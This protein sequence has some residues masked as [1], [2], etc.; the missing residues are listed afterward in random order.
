MKSIIN[1]KQL[2]LFVILLYFTSY[3]T[4]CKKDIS[5]KPN[6]IHN[7]SIQN[8]GAI[9]YSF[10]CEDTAH[11]WKKFTIDQFSNPIFH[12]GKLSVWRVFYDLNDLNIIYYLTEEIGIQKYTLWKYN[13]VS[14]VKTHLADNLLG[15][16][17]INKNGWLVYDS[18]TDLNLYRIKSNGDSLKQLTFDG[19]S[20]FPRWTSDGKHIWFVN[21][22]PTLGGIFKMDFNGNRLDTLFNASSWAVENNNFIYFTKSSN[23]NNVLNVQLFQKN[24]TTKS[25]KIILTLVDGDGSGKDLYDFFP[26]QNN[27]NLY[28][29][30][31][32]G[33]SK[34]NLS[35]LE[36]KLI[37]NGAANSLNRYLHYRQNPISKNFIFIQFYINPISPQLIEYYQKVKELNENGTCIRTINLVD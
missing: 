37:I 30:G 7:D 17:E 16:V 24:L 26:D 22:G 23:P 1:I 9:N 36:T 19:S 10:T 12:T 31:A 32:H 4:N 8:N 2:S 6:I 27:Q 5:L 25:E 3:L 13:L 11:I 15:N 35:S 20:K 28:W 21:D 14:K 33:L 18:F 29:W 34:T